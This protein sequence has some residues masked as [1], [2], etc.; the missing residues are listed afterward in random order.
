[1]LQPLGNAIFFIFEDDTTS[2]KFVNKA[3]SGILIAAGAGDQSNIPR[4][5]TVIDVGPEVDQ[6]K[7]GDYILIEPGKWTQGFQDDHMTL[8]LRLWKTD[9]NHVLCTSDEPIP[10]Y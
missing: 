9:E 5:G 6:V 4:W 2:T 3:A 10:A 8:G 1:M 7:A